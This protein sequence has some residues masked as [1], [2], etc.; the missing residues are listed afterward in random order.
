MKSTPM[1]TILFA[2]HDEF[3]AEKDPE[4]AS[5][6]KCEDADVPEIFKKY[7]YPVS[8]WPV[9]IDKEMTKEI[10]LLSVRIP[11]LIAQIPKLYFNNDIQKIA[12]FYL[13]GDTTLAEFTMMCQDKNILPSSRLDVTYSDDGFK[14][15]EANVGS[16]IGGWQVQSFDE[17]I[18]SYHSLLRND[19]T[20]EQFISRNT[21]INYIEFIIDEILRSVTG[22]DKEINLFIGVSEG[23]DDVIS[24]EETSN[25]FQDAVN[26]VCEGRDLKMNVY[27][28]DRTKLYLDGKNLC[29]NS[30]RLHGLLDMDE[31]EMPPIVFRAY[32]L[33]TLYFPD[34]L[35]TNMYGDKRNLAL[36]RFLAE[37][38]KFSEADNRLL[39]KCM[40]WTVEFADKVVDFKGEKCA[41]TDL[42]KRKDDF[43]IKP[44]SGFQGKGV[45]V[46][47]F[48]TQ[49]E[50]DVAIAENLNTGKFILQEFCD[51]ILYLA[52]NKN[53]EW[54][55]HK[56]IWGMFGFDSMYGGVWVRMSE[57]AT[58]VGVINSAKGAVEAIVYEIL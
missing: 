16:T 19:V 40:P 57:A 38:G 23:Q 31:K 32:L 58:D 37:E 9:L 44:F 28:D 55:P 12:D 20:K 10:K 34:N 11:K 13:E 21:Q 4:L 33:G 27:N 14:V 17:E 18:R 48:L 45:H 54:T 39:K 29:Y 53:N 52:P 7:H 47:K 49:S 41:V 56:L 51:S 1:E 26:Y 22:I 2:K 15:L 6:V 42:I 24:S 43:V 8:T 46:G 35:A 36:L 30:I 5:L 25:F 50:W 3:I